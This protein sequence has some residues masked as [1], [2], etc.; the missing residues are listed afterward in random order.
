M[1]WWGKLVGG[2]FGFV[3]GGPLGA[4]IGAALGHQFDVGAPGRQRPF[5]A[6]AN[7]RTQLA[8]F[9]AVFS[10]MGHLAKA[11]GHV[12]TSEIALAEQ[13]MAHMQLNKEQ[14][15]LAILLFNQGKQ[16]DFQFAE[17]M[18]QFR[19]ECHR[20]STLYRFFLEI[21][22]QAALADGRIDPLESRILKEAAAA[23]DFTSAELD[24]LIEMVRG[25]FASHAGT[26]PVTLQ[27]VTS[28]CPKRPIGNIRNP[29]NTTK[30]Y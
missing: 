13:L 25:A 10:V 4:I 1:T 28:I 30:L 12:S 26:Q 23:L 3:L 5:G 17:I 21:Q 24:Q 14:K 11:D 15:K 9:T 20:R 2:T 16:P 7:E 18:E 22:I 6:N 27:R 29:K 8:F 19:R